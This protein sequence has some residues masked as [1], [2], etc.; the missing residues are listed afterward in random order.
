VAFLKNL[1]TAL[2]STIIMSVSFALYQYDPAQENPDVAGFSF[3]GYLVFDFLYIGTIYLFVIVP[4]SLWIN[5]KFSSYGPRLRLFS[6]AGILIGVLLSLYIHSEL[7]V[8]DPEG[9]YIVYGLVSL[10]AAVV[11]LHIYLLLS[12]LFNRKRAEG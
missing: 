9:I 2:L 1:I 3:E 8:P 7:P 5:A 11:Y 6:L 10:A 12:A 4:L